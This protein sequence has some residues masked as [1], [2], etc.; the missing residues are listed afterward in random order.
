MARLVDDTSGKI[1]LR[2]G[3]HLTLELITSG[4]Q[5]ENRISASFGY[6]LRLEIHQGSHATSPMLCHF[7]D[8]FLLIVDLLRS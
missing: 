2:A 7:L 5:V 6:V 1:D 8:C 3:L 4:K